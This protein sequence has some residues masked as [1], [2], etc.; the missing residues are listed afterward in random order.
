MSPESRAEYF[1]DRRKKLKQLVFMIDREKADALDNVLNERQESRA[2]WFRR[3]VDRE[4]SGE[5]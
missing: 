4:I 5:K 2:S 1:R 3:I